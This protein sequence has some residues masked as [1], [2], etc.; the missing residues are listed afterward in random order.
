MDV[1]QGVM[2]FAP[3]LALLLRPALMRAPALASPWL[4]IPAIAASSLY[5]YL[6]V[7]VGYFHFLVVPCIFAASLLVFRKTGRSP[8]DSVVL[9]FLALVACDQLWQVPVYAFDWS[10]SLSALRAGLVTVPFDMMA[11]PFFFLVAAPRLEDRSR[12]AAFLAIGLTVAE[13]VRAFGGQYQVA[14]YPVGWEPYFLVFVW[15]PFFLLSG[16]T[17]RAQVRLEQSG[18]KGLPISSPTA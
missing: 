12:V 13:V 11:V 10:Q 6:R 18:Q 7:V 9:A 5:V 3:A 17:C 2:I 1:F 8:A 16:S 14:P 15:L 4:W